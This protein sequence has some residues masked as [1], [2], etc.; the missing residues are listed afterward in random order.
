MAMSVKRVLVLVL[1]GFVLGASCSVRVADSVQPAALIGLPAGQPAADESAIEP[2]VVTLLADDF[3]GGT[4]HWDLDSNWAIFNDG[5]NQVL[6]G[7]NHAW[8]TPTL[9]D[10][11]TDYTFTAQVRRID[12][13]VQLLFRMS[14][15]R[16]RYIVGV[17][18]GGLYLR[19]ESPW[20]QFS[21]DLATYAASFAAWDWHKISVEVALRR[22]R[23]TV[24]DAPTPQI[25]YTDLFTLNKWPLWQGT[26]GLEVA[27]SGSP[28]Q[29]QFDDVQVVGITSPEHEWVKTGG[30]IGGLGYDVRYGSA[31]R[32][33]MYVTDNYA[34]VYKSRDGGNTWFGSNRGI[35]GRFWPS[36]DAIPNF[37]LTVDPNN[38]DI[39]WAGLKD[40]K[41][42]YKSTNGGQTW[43]DVTASLGITE[44]EFVFRG[45]TIMPG[46]SDKVFAQ[47]ELPLNITGRE[48]GKVK[49][50][51][52]YT[53]DGGSSWTKIWEGQDLT[54]Y[55]IVRPDNHNIIYAS[56][57]IFDREAA[58]SDCTLDSGGDPTTRGGVGVLR[59]EWI[60]PT[61]NWTEFNA[62]NGLT[63][64]YVGSLVMHPTDPDILLAGAGNNACSTNND[65]T[66]TGGVFLSTNGGLTWTHTLDNE[67]ITS[68]ESAPS[69]PNIAYAGGRNRFYASGD[70]GQTWN[71]VNGATIAW[72]PPGIIAGFPIDV[73]VDPTNP[74]VLFANNY[75]GGNV[76]SADGGKTWTLASKGYTGALM[77]DVQSHP[78]S[79]GIVYASARS[80]AFRSMDGGSTW[81]GLVYPP[82]NLVETYSIAMSPEN[83]LIVLTAG[84]LDGKLYRSTDGGFGWTLVKELTTTFAERHGFKRVVF[85]P[86]YGNVVYAGSCTARG[87]LHGGKRQSYGVYTSADAGAHWADP[88][89]VD[90]S[91][92]CINDLAVH[93][94]DPGIAYAATAS[95][96]LYRTDDGGAN[97]M[98][99]TLSTSP[100]VT[101]VRS[102]AIRPDDPNVLYAG[103]EFGGAY[104]S[105][106]GGDDWTPLVA[107]M[108]P[109]DSIWALEFDPANPEV[110]Y[111]GSFFSGVYRWIPDEAMWTHV[112]AGL[113]TRAVVDL[114]ISHD[115]QVLYAATWGEGVF[116]LGEVPRF[117]VYLPLVLRN[118]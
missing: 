109:N 71:L 4:D 77:F 116:R 20:G 13:T 28:P 95:G 35:V 34:G 72:G 63:D 76:K 108:E 81:E 117:P 58:N 100:V 7:Q 38:P 89:D 91:D 41:G 65:S 92:K 37:S 2:Q 33:V 114:A 1:V 74:N 30:P 11:W 42:V 21:G 73:L 53:E 61:W 68:V 47:G 24:D 54:R 56:A 86:S 12:G 66:L 29:A 102:V 18:P 48:F 110:V 39:V 19:K 23:V 101:D 64:L 16:G 103:V 27:G 98:Q 99:L 88:T 10:N 3:E 49:G 60:S 115:G 59:G 15:D 57:G 32:Q 90:I 69:N 62:A 113:R 118:Y 93:P 105:D 87:P 50:R 80:G 97:W 22:I 55:V 46:E 106:N 112:N 25:D 5:G 14:N 9:G 107:G 43:T 94:V 75:G 44:T 6:E 8:A 40:V 67:I 45:F 111:A 36:G 51:I 79:P 85:A 31:D 84:E 17:N 83:P 70:G 96:G 78:S 82:A 26:I 52:Y 104:R